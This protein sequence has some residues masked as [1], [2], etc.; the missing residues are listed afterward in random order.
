M[1]TVSAMSGLGLQQTKRDKLETECIDV[2]Y[3]NAWMA[4]AD[5]GLRGLPLA[6]SAF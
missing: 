3:A 2:R 4:S 1:V 6:L 5:D